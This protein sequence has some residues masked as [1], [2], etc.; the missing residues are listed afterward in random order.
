MLDIQHVLNIRL[1]AWHVGWAIHCAGSQLSLRCNWCW[2]SSST[3]GALQDRFYH[4][5]HPDFRVGDSIHFLQS[6][7]HVTMENLMKS[8]A[9]SFNRWISARSLQ[10]SSENAEENGTAE[11]LRFFAKRCGIRDLIYRQVYVS[12]WFYFELWTE[13]I[14]AKDLTM[15]SLI[16]VFIKMWT[17]DFEV[18]KNVAIFWILLPNLLSWART[19]ESFS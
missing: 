14:W 3:L 12:F 4:V 15:W 18:N 2:W 13:K 5:L 11:V 7:C 19:Q 17:I 10:M 9:Q 6:P 8:N 1:C 16:Y